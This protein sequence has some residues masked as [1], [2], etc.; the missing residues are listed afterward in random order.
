MHKEVL[1]DWTSVKINS[2]N[3]I[4]GSPTN[5]CHTLESV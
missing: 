2:D 1:E 4:H 5:K 3:K